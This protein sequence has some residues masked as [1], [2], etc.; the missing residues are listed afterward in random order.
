MI[1]IKRIKY[2]NIIPKFERIKKNY[3]RQLIHLAIVILLFIA[4][5]NI[6]TLKRM[7]GALKYINQNQSNNYKVKC[8]LPIDEPKIKLY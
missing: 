6:I 2:K 4:N 1:F 5:L 7:N 3:S 8:Y